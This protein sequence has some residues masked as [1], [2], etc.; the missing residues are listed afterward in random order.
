MAGDKQGSITR[1][2]DGR[3]TTGSGWKK[4]ESGNPKGRQPIHE[5]LTSLLKIE[6]EKTCPDDDSGRS[7]KERIVLAT[8]RLAMQGNAAALRE[9]WERLDGKIPQPPPP[10][11]HDG[12]PVE[13]IIT[14]GGQKEP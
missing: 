7:W 5:C 10:R 12:E 3:F 4:G 8:M 6:I 2:P 1:T 9:I 14:Y 11:L 13:F